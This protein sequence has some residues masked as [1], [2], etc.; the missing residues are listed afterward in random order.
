MRE[1]RHEPLR[2]RFGSPEDHAD[3]LA[4]V[5]A[6]MRLLFASVSVIPADVRRHAMATFGCWIFDDGAVALGTPTAAIKVT[7]PKEVALYV[8][9]FD[10]LQREA[11]RG[12]AARRLIAAVTMDQ[13]V[14]ARK[15]RK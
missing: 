12:E 13:R 1:E 4:R 15:S 14:H 3:Q 9:M 10:W 2:T 6:V 7:R 11:V 8:S 5:L